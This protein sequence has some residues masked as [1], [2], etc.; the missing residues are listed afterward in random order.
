MK[1]YLMFEELTPIC[2]ALEI[3]IGTG[4]LQLRRLSR[5][6]GSVT[7]ITPPHMH[8]AFNAQ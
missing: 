6:E 4:R 2:T 1:F 8:P 3:M 7:P 5:F